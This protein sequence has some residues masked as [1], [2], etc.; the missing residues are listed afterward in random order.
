MARGTDNEERTGSTRAATGGALDADQTVR[1]ADRL[2]R[3]RVV[4]RARAAVVVVARAALVIAL[5]IALVRTL[6]IV[7]LV[8]VLVTSG[9]LDRLAGG[10]CLVCGRLELV[11]EATKESEHALLGR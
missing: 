11:N 7:V 6:V 5:V 8:V 1:M 4:V 9:E 10:G 3:A 2:V